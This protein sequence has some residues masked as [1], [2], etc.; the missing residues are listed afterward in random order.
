M[1]MSAM[2]LKTYFDFKKIKVADASKDLGVTKAHIYA[3]IA[4][5]YEPGRKLAVRIVAW[6]GNAVQLSDL[7]NQRIS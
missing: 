6:S 7:W 5:T 2:D 4:G 1:Q 3:L